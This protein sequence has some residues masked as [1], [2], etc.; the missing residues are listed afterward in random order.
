MSIFT[1]RPCD[2]EEAARV[3]R[4]QLQQQHAQDQRRPAEHPQRDAQNH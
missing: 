1:T 3:Q 4:P 2:S